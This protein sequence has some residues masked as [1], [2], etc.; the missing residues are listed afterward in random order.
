MA[1]RLGK[2]FFVVIAAVLAIFL[3]SLFT[4]TWT[5]PLTV[6]GVILLAALSFIVFVYLGRLRAAEGFFDKAN[7]PSVTFQF[8]DDG[9][10]TESDLG[11]TNLKWQVFEEILKFPDIWLLVYAKSGYMT[12]PI[13]QLTP[14]CLQFIEEQISIRK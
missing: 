9:V 10:I 7:E 5:W 14:G 8:T 12:L 13:D 6:L 2:S 11:R 3:V 1:R 4:G